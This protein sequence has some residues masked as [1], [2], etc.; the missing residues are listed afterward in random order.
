MKVV[1]IYRGVRDFLKGYLGVV[2]MQVLGEDIDYDAPRAKSQ[3]GV[4]VTDRAVLEKKV[5]SSVED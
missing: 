2:R 4:R 5:L 3:R 1:G